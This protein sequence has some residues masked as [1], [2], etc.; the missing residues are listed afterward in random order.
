MT[1]A[2][3]YSSLLSFAIGERCGMKLLDAMEQLGI[4][5]DKWRDEKIETWKY[6]FVD[7]SSILV[8]YFIRGRR[9][10]VNGIV[11][12]LYTVALSDRVEVTEGK[13]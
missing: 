3:Q 7:G 1:Q 9:Q 11:G 13:K 10:T 5:E 6:R 8:S 2:E 4:L 12:H